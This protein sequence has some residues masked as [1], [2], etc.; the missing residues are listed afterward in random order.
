[1]NVAGKL[2][3]SLISRRLEDHI[4]ENK[5]INKSIQKGCMEKIPG[6][7]EHMSSIWDSL[8]SSNLARSDSVIILGDFNETFDSLLLSSFLVDHSLASLITSPTCFKSSDSKCID[9]ILT[10]R[11]RCFMKR[12]SL[13]TGISDFHHLIYSV[14]KSKFVKIPSIEIS[15]RCL[16]NFQPELFQQELC[17]NLQNSLSTNF[18]VFHSILENVLNFHAPIK[19]R[20]IRG[21]QKPHITK[22]L[23]KAIMKRSYYKN[24]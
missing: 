1:M 6:C 19:K 13:E 3:F 14:F 18:S 4:N 17:Y 11:S 16:R 22:E 12:N 9:L 24:K 15:Y 20:R 23:R 5:F 8:K 10:N 21:N 2:F 7:W